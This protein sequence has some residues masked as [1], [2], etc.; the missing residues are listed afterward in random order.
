MEI[1]LVGEQVLGFAQIGGCRQRR[2][3]MI[4]CSSGVALVRAP[5]VPAADGERVHLAQRTA[6]AAFPRLEMAAAD[7]RERL[8]GLAGLIV[9]RAE[10]DAE[11]IAL[12]DEVEVLFEFAQT[13][14]PALHAEAFPELIAFEQQPCIGR[15]RTGTPDHR[16][17]GLGRVGDG[18]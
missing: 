4:A 2:L 1:A 6:F 14:S 16:R 9:E 8:G 11:I 17:R 10:F 3:E 13:S 18:C 5:P 12:A 7:Q 15:I